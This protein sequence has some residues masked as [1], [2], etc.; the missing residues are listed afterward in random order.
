MQARPDKAP[1]ANSEGAEPLLDESDLHEALARAA[2]TQWSWRA[3]IEHWDRC[4]ATAAHKPHRL[5]LTR[6]AYCLIEIGQIDSARDLFTSLSDHV[7]GMKGLVAIAMLQETRQHA[8]ALWDE[9]LARFPDHIAGV[10]GK[11]ELLLRREM[12]QGADKLLSRVVVTWPD[13]IHAGV[14]WAECAT[15]AKDWEIAGTRWNSLLGKWPSQRDVQQGYTRYLAALGDR[16]AAAQYLA[17]LAD[18][19]AVLAACALE[20]HVANDDY[21]EAAHQAAELAE[22]EPQRL[23]HQLRLA[24]LLMRDGAELPLRAAL[25]IL[26]SLY[27]ISPESLSVITNLADAFIRSGQDSQA[28]RLIQ[29]IPAADRRAEVEVLR[30]W[31]QHHRNNEDAAKATWIAI[32][33]RQYVPAI[34]APIANLTR[35]DRNDIQIGRDDILL[36]SVIRN[37]YPRLDWFLRYYRKLGINKFVVVDNASTDQSAKFLLDNQDVILYQTP[38]RYSAAGAGTRW[39]NELID[40]HGRQNWCLYVD[41]DE[42][43]VFP[44]YEGFGLRKLIDYLDWK[45]CEAMLAVMLDMYPAVVDKAPQGGLETV[46]ASYT[47]FDDRHFVHGSPVCPYREVFGGVRRRLF[48]GYQLANKVPLIN[49]AAGVKFL[50]SSHRITPAKLA[51]I[52]GGLLHYHLLY[53][54]Q[55]EYLPLFNEAIERREFP[56]NSLERLRC[57]ELLRSATPD[58]LL[59]EESVR[60]ETSEQLLALG[61]DQSIGLPHPDDYFLKF[62]RAALAQARQ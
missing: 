12:Y 26:K 19:P 42:A 14:L 57:R 33:D 45:G 58:T 5:A 46:Q 17:S 36:F 8:D 53:A 48:K 15:K 62:M 21:V 24:V 9:C 61:K 10:L 7:E 55:P 43:L 38:D 28:R 35:I 6:K 16:A 44:G 41:A 13:S 59:A 3:A 39:V 60:F 27:Q 23:E 52:T 29:T 30:A 54:L 25:S 47:Y 49:G 32:L 50:L 1:A 11:A 2:E 4:A 34:H 37:E 18:Q 31:L 20:Y 51:G 56:R 22:L 40:R